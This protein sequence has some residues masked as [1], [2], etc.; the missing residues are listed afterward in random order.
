MKIIHKLNSIFSYKE[1]EVE[2]A[3]VW[4]VYWNIYKENGLGMLYPKVKTLSKAFLNEY[5]AIEFK[6]NLEKC[7]EILQF[8][9]DINIK[10]EKQE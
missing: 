1:K 5:D 10:I 4:M 3:E 2:G 6:N 9:V 8:K 7:L